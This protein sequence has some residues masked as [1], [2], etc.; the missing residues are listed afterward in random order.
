[1]TQAWITGR[2]PSEQISHC[3]IAGAYDI[4][5]ASTGIEAL[6]MLDQ[7]FCGDN[8]EIL[9]RR[10]IADQSIDLVYL[11]PPFNSDT[12]NN[13]LFNKRDGALAAAFRETW[14]WGTEAQRE[15]DD[16]IAAGG[17][18]G[19]LMTLYRVLLDGTD[20]LAYLAMMAPR[21]IELHRVLR[22]TGS[23]YLHCDPRASHY[24][25]TL[26][27]AVFGPT[28]FKN[29]IIWK[30]TS[31]H[32]G[33]HRYGP[34]HDTLF[35]YTKTDDFTWNEQ[36]GSYDSTYI[37][38]F[39]THTDN[40]G[41]KWCRTDLT[42][43]GIR[44]GDSGLPW[45]GYNP[46]ARKR[47]WQPPSYFYEKYKLLTGDDLAKY[48]LIERLDKLSNAGLI[49]WPEK[50]GGMP[51]GKRLLEDA[52]G[53]PLQDVWTDIKPL[54]NLASERVHYPTQKPGALL[55]RIIRS[56]SNPGDV[57]LDPFCGCGTTIETA[58]DEERRWIGIDISFDAIRVI[59]K[60]RIA[61]FESDFKYEMIWWPRD[62]EA[63]T[64]FAVEQ[65]FPFQDW[66]V[67]KLD[68]EIA[69]H[70][71]GDKGIDG[72]LYFR[73]AEN[74]PFRTIIVSV[75]GG[76]L[77]SPFVRELAGAVASEHAPMG[78]LVV[79]QKQSKQMVSDAAKY[80]FYVGPLGT[81]PKIQI[82]TVQDILDNARLNL[83]PIHKMARA[84]RSRARAAAQLPLPGI[85]G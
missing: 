70:R 19:E 79:L 81:F 48:G 73:E 44:H 45:G 31:A 43:P 5:R 80:G 62:L 14:Q 38:A 60:D 49:H 64:A 77:K 13:L 27:D 68:G 71:S 9:R 42:G 66:I 2:M 63:A 50:E 65:P 58:W 56:S 84:K 17:K 55:K 20:M 22:P 47:H 29:E 37:N 8:L 39:F 85:A 30:R 72:K 78:I 1:M 36:Y 6:A 52:K 4:V 67:E 26:L 69:P 34:V 53:I 3:T 24:L 51:R 21:L 16:L 82:I 46:T 83:P 7:L 59:R 15:L 25:K 76:K 11:D 41:R 35:F 12:N 23:L 75:K 32:S 57:I 54:H 74:S 40:Q 10:D 28:G 61:K 18:L 33:A